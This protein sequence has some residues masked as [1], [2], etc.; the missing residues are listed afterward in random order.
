MKMKDD[1][2]TKAGS[3]KAGDA[4]RYVLELLEENE[5]LRRHLESLEN[6]LGALTLETRHASEQY[7][8]LERRSSHLA[9]L[10]VA[11]QRLTASTDTAEVVSA[12]QDIVANLMGSEEIAI[13]EL[14]SGDR[15]LK[16][17]ASLG[18]DSTRWQSVELGAGSIG[19]AAVSGEPFM[20]RAGGPPAE[21]DDLSACVPLLLDGRVTGVIAIFKLL[22]QKPGLERADRELLELLATQAA[23][24]LHYSGLSTPR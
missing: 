21:P 24:A 5:R 6:R 12:I 20:A 19:R 11:S 18:I 4:P 1:D 3:V 2:E 13:F 16:L 7:V 23:S 14:E 10:Y 15:E 8:K 17:K 9:S 22:P